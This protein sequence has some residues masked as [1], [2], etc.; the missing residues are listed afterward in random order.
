M[1]VPRRIV[2]ADGDEA[3]IMKATVATRGAQ[4]E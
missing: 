2:E 3:A 4:R 1:A